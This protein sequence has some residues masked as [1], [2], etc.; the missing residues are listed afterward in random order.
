MTR[1]RIFCTLLFTNNKMKVVI[2]MHAFKL[3]PKNMFN[4][5]MI[6]SN[7]FDDSQSA[8]FCTTMLLFCISLKE[9]DEIKKRKDSTKIA[10]CESSQYS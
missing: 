2:Q 7:N 9:K 3:D 10:D 6:A 5:F 4:K 1:V 8:S